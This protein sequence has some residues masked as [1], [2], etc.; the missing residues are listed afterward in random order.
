MGHPIEVRSQA[1]QNFIGGILDATEC[2]G[3]IQGSHASKMVNCS[4]CDFFKIVK[5]E[6]GAAFVVGV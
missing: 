1:L 3:K 2:G 4:T 6:Q 5:Q